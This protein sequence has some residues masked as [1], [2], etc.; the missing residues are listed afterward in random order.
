MFNDPSRITPMNTRTIKFRAWSKGAN[1]ANR[2]FGMFEWEEFKSLI[3]EWI[4]NGERAVEV[5]QY[6]GLKDKNGKEIYE[7]HEID[8]KYRVIYKAP[9][10][11]LQD[12]SNGDIIDLYDQCEITG[13]YAPIP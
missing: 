10:Y 4:A 3:C 12:I 8:G 1:G 6:T 13:E 11:V 9:K 2:E 7:L 5:M